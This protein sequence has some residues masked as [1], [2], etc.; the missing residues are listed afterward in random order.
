MKFIEIKKSELKIITL[1]LIDEKIILHPIISPVGIPDFS[2]YK[3]RKFIVILDRNILV[4]I[5]RLVNNGELKDDHSLKIVSCLLA[6]S[7][8]NN[9]VLN[10]GLALTEYSH[11]H[12]GN[13]ESSKENNIFLHIYKQYSPRDWFDLATG[14]FKTIKRIELQKERDFEFFVEGDHFKMHYLEMLKLS[15]LYFNDELE[16]VKKFELFFK[17]VFQNIL[18]CKYTTYF[19]IMLL[20]N[21]SKTFR[22]KTINYESVNLICKNVAW[23]LTYLSFWSTQYYF[24]KDAEHVYLFATMDK[25]LRELFFLTHKESLEICKEVF[26]EKNGQIIINS[27]SNIY[28]SRSKPE[29]NPTALDKLVNEEQFNLKEQLN[30]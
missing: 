21:K 11:H 4:R 25:E 28:L 6:W 10:S 15:Q 13:I 29:I 3:G 14:K 12:G 17:W 20:G 24:E 9:I 30:K 26:G 22:N 19:A 23:D 5:L 18:I 2:E 7:V 27:I 16:I 1:F 8:F